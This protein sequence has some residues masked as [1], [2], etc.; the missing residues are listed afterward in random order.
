MELTVHYAPDGPQHLQAVGRLYETA[1][2]RVFF[3]YD[4]AWSAGPRELSP[5]FLPNSTTGAAVSPTPAFGPLFGLFEDAL[6]DWWGERLMRR[7]FGELGIRWNQVTSLQKLACGGERKMGALTFSPH[8]ER[9]SLDDRRTL[10][11]E[12]MTLAAQA[13]VDGERSEI[14]DRLIP[15]G[16]TPGGAQPKALLSFTADFSRI[17]PTEPPDDTFSPW[18]LKFELHPELHECRVEHAYHL[19]AAAAGI[20]VPETRLISSHDGTRAHFLSR[21]FDRAAGGRRIHMHTFSGLTHTPPRDG[22]DY[23]DLMNLTRQL[24]RKHPDVEQVFRR[25]VFNIAAGNDDDHG[26]NHAFLMDPD[27][28]W[29]LSPAYDLTLVTHPLVA[30]IRAGAVQGKMRAITRDDLIRLGD[31]HGVRRIPQAIDTI[32]DTIAHWPDFARQAGI[33][34]RITADCQDRMPLLG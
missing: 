33:P 8:L 25:A 28:T 19:M 16:L 12:Q 17:G 21:R 27:G 26:R 34:P 3:E 20:D 14:L 24:T 31:E 13:A 32:L 30:G 18:L 1:Q 29:R 23:H 6:P 22:T 10:D 7:F 9:T 2:G 11:I 5:L 4:P 15:S